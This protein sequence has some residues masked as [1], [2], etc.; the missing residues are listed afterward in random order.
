MIALFVFECYNKCMKK[1]L[2]FFL[3]AFLF[4]SLF[5]ICSN[6]ERFSSAIEIG[7]DAKVI[8]SRCELYESADFLS[9]K[10][11]VVKNDEEEI[12]YIWHG[13]SVGV[14]A[15]EGD[16]IKIKTVDE[17]EGYVY[18]YYLTQN[19]SQIVYPVFNGT[20]R[21][22]SEIYDLDFKPSP[23]SIKKGERVFIY[24][25]YTEKKGYTS[26]QVV[27]DDQTLYNG[28]VMT[29]DVKPDGISGLLISGISVIVAG[30]TVTLSV[31]FI[32]KKKKK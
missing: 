23:Y 27:L 15:E 19:T 4:V 8:A 26:V 24:K 32:K 9:N 18:K 22:D 28:Y 21:N 10:V 2:P 5:S 13:D 30:V 17:I 6:N 7:K 3:I 1:I 20:M 14:L 12:Y 11:T 29:K 16:F 31:V 25:S